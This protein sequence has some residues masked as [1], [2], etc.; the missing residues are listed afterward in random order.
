MKTKRIISSILVTLLLLLLHNCSNVSSI[1]PQFTKDERVPNRSFSAGEFITLYSVT[2]SKYVSVQNDSTLYANS[3]IVNNS[4][5]FVIEN[6]TSGNIRLKSVSDGNYL[7]ISSNSD[8]ASTTTTPGEFTLI[9]R[10]DNSYSLYSVNTN[11]HLNVNPNDNNA[12]KAQWNDADGGWQQFYIKSVGSQKIVGVDLS[13]ALYAQNNGVIFKDE[14]GNSKDVFEI[15]YDSGYTWVRVRVNIEPESSDY[16]M[17]TDLAYAKEVGKKVKKLG[18]KLLV[19]F[20]YSHWWADPGNQWTPTSW[21]T[22]DSVT[23]STTVYNWTKNAVTEFIDSGIE[24]DMIQIGN[25]IDYGLL[26]DLGNV[27]ESTSNWTNVAWFINSGINAVADAGSNADIMLHTATGGSWSQTSAWIENF[28]NA[29]GQWDD[30]DAYGLSYYSMWHGTTTDLSNNLTNIQNSYP[31]KDIYVI[32]TAYYWDT[33]ELNYSGS[34]VPYPQTQQGQYDFLQSVKSVI[35]QIENVKGV[36][37]WGAAWAQT[38]HWL[39]AS[40]WADDDASRRSL[41]DDDGKVTLGLRGLID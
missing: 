16:A 22:T 32:E 35:N 29:G 34:A 13:E 23:L 11:T 7:S 33:N 30:V 38:D 40:G 9:D 5:T 3:D 19:D 39:N 4:S 41:F 28:K 2:S 21:R 15:F 1:T 17:F 27:G 31:D 14:N 37:Y 10:G 8:I 12:I 26:W 18:F 24:P 20:H 25:E 36:F 6:S